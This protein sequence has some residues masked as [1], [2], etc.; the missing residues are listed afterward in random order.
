MKVELYEGNLVA[1]E[2]DKV[3]HWVAVIQSHMAKTVQAIIDTGQALIDAKADCKHG[4]FKA[5]CQVALGG[6]GGYSTAERLMAIAGSDQIRRSAQHLPPAWT[7]LYEL[8]QLPEKAFT[9]A[10]EK[11]TVHP[12]MT[13]A[14]AV[15]LKPKPRVVIDAEVIEVTTGPR[16]EDPTAVT[17]AGAP[18]TALIEGVCCEPGCNEPVQDGDEVCD[19]CWAIKEPEIEAAER[20]AAKEAAKAAKALRDASEFYCSSCD[21]VVDPDEGDIRYYECGDCGSEF[22][23]D[24]G[25]GKGN[26]CPDCNKF[27]ARRE[28]DFCPNCEEELEQR[29]PANAEEVA[30][31]WQ[32]S[33]VSGLELLPGV[34]SIAD[35]TT[36]E[37]GS[38]QA[39]VHVTRDE[40][41]WDAVDKMHAS[42]QAPEGQGSYGNVYLSGSSNDG[43]FG[44]VWFECA[45]KGVVQLV[46]DLAS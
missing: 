22:T 29:Q 26:Q 9:K 39:K 36:Y 33:V 44:V 17:A 18:G 23:S 12:L 28:G 46:R 41:G 4:D 13:R 11:G 7:T 24:E 42:V 30:E 25:G 37:C 45:D 27:A 31:G 8:A 2:Q 10:V 15:E 40:A 35:H 43:R 19:S 34:D 32:L 38:W 3:D 5:V 16:A 14:A 20:K 21:E 6:G 1:L